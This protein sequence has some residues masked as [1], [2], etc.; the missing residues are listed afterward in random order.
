M[1]RTRYKRDESDDG[2]HK[3]LELEISARLLP[4][5][6]QLRQMVLSEANND[7]LWAE[8]CYADLISYRTFDE[9]REVMARESIASMLELEIYKAASKGTIRV[10]P[11]LAWCVF[12]NNF[13]GRN[14]WCDAEILA[15]KLLWKLAELFVQ[16]E[17]SREEEQTIVTYFANLVNPYR[18]RQYDQH[19]MIVN[20][21]MGFLKAGSSFKSSR[22]DDLNS[23]A[24]EA[25]YRFRRLLRKYRSHLYSTL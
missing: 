16:A 11:S 25:W 17:L 1:L 10:D 13:F 2:R 4:V 7:L 8:K 19:P 23:L 9:L 6:R 15:R 5:R 22:N 20:T 12:R 14:N 21:I 18:L 3:L 24:I